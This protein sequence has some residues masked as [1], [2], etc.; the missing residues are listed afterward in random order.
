MSPISPSKA[1]PG[2]ASVGAFVRKVGGRVRANMTGESERE[3]LKARE[4]EG[5]REKEKVRDIKK[6]LELSQF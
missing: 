6:V 1:L 2:R 4:R 3:K 5:G